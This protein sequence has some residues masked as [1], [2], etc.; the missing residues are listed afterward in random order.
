MR[1]S[2]AGTGTVLLLT[3]NENTDGF[4]GWLEEIEGDVVVVQD[5]IDK[6]AAMRLVPVF[7]V[8]FNY[9]HIMRADAIEALGVPRRQRALLGPAME[10][11]REPELLQLLRE[12]S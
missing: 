6:R 1:E 2:S 4:R 7:V 10:Q 12:H 9:R 8:S 5:P 3:N 11:G